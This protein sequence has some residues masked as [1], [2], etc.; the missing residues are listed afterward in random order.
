MM[1]EISKSLLNKKTLF[2]AMFKMFVGSFV[3]KIGIL[4]TKLP[5]FLSFWL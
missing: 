3:L 4:S 5:K 1:D 2:L